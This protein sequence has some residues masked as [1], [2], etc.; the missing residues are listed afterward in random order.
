[1]EDSELHARWS[2]DATD[3]FAVSL[4]PELQRLWRKYFQM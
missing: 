4:F 1:M 2:M 3:V